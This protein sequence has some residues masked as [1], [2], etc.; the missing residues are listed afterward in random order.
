MRVVLLIAVLL[1]ALCHPAVGQ[2][3]FSRPYEP[4]QIVVEAVVPELP[5][6]DS[7]FPSGATFLTATRSLNDNV[8]LAAELPL[9]HYAQGG[10]SAS[11]VGNP[12]VGVGLSSTRIPLLIELG[13]RL[14]TV[15]S[16]Q[17][18]VV[19]RRA[20]LGRTAAFRDEAVSLSGLL[21]TRLA[22]SRAT[23]LRLRAG[24]TYASVDTDR[25]NHAAHWEVPYSAQLWWE[26]PRLLTGLSFVGRPSINEAPDAGR[27]RHRAVLSVMRNGD[28]FQPGLMLGTG[29]DPLFEDGQ[30]V[31]VG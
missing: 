29:L 14:P 31:F 16:N 26:R 19:G 3:V 30:I 7:S 8:Q 1:G 28:R 11:A 27:A 12:Y 23:S 20:D 10:T 21:N 9:A 2:T 13:V 15:P 22:L 25:T 17:A 5:N 18:P 6:Q 24:L 4:N